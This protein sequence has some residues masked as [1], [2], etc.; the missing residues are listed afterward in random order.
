MTSFEINYDGLVGPS[1]NYA[2]L[3]FGNVASTSHRAL[4]SNPREAALQG[5]EKMRALMDLGFRQGVFAPHERPDLQALRRLGFT[6]SSEEALRSALAAKPELFAA[7]ASASSMWVANAATTCPSADSADGKVHFTPANLNSKLHRAI[8]H[9]TTGRLLKGMFPP[10]PAFVHHDALPSSE[11]MGDE[12]AANHTR[13]CVDHGAPGLHFFVYGRSAL[14]GG[15][16]PKRF[17]ARQSR[18]A[19]EAVARLHGLGSDRCFFAQQAPEAIDAGAFHNDVVSV[20]NRHVLF[21]HERAYLDGPTVLRDLERAFAGACGATLVRIEVKE[22]EV[23][24]AD[25]V[26]SYLFNSQLVNRADGG[27]ALVAPRECQETES[28]RAYL[29]AVLSAG[30]TPI[31]EVRYFDLR[32]SMRNGGGPACLRFR[33]VLNDDELVHSNKKCLLTPELFDRLCAWVKIHY[34]D[35]LSL[36]DLADPRFGLESRRALD[37]LTQILGLGSVY[38]FQL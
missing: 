12:G 28:V 7:C 38:P 35:R 25:A 11:A 9:P 33:V 21:H 10:G 6:G 4:V 36:S 1:H 22:S 27:M 20:G 32:Q 13:L 15:V 30:T 18:E 24:L 37:E 31:K 16:E 8:E 23:P 26:R 14:G 17:P 5:L 19:A 34:R 29:G 3:S 2:G